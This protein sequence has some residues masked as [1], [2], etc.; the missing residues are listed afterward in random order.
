NTQ[1]TG[2]MNFRNNHDGYAYLE[3]YYD[4]QLDSV[5][6]AKEQIAYYK[7]LHS[8]FEEG[9]LEFQSYQSSIDAAQERDT[10]ALEN[11]SGKESQLTVNLGKYADNIEYLQAQLD[12][13]SLT[14]SQETTAKEQLQTWQELYDYT[15]LI[16]TS[17]QKLNGTYEETLSVLDQVNRKYAG[18][19]SDGAAARVNRSDEQ[20]AFW[21]WS[22]DL[23]DEQL[24]LVNSDAFEKAL[25]K[26]K[27]GLNNASLSAENYAGALKEL[28]S[29]EKNAFSFSPSAF[30][31]S[32]SA[33]S[34]LQDTYN[35]F[36]ENAKDN[37]NFTFNISD[38][39]NLR[40]TFGNTCAE[41]ENFENLL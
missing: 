25:E 11:L 28:E 41:F 35:A 24:E 38:I 31:E 2:E 3:K 4:K 8:A 34:S 30:S 21:D 7:E 40:E 18:G 16:I 6:S 36:Y 17:I 1:Y 9:S 27:Q 29:K 12:S 5:K 13:G 20:Q 23:N 33:L 19:Y 32:I 10:K 37:K 39:E 15:E 22:K 14:S 26:Q